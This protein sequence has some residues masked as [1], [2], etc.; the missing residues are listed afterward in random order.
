[1]AAIGGINKD[2]LG[3]VIKAGADSA[4]VI[5]AVMGAED[6]EK[7]TRKLAEIFREYENGKS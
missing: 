5:S 4:A 1:V 7:A 6:I 3:E 2:N